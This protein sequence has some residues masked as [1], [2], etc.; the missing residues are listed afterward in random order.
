[1]HRKQITD[2][3]P[4]DTELEKTLR[5]LRKIKK[6]ENS[7]MADE[8]QEHNDEH[9]EAVRRPPITDTMEDFWRPII[10]DE[11]SAIRQ[12]AVEANN[13][14]LKPALITMVQQHQFTGHPTEDP[15][16]HLGRFLRMANTVKL[17][18]VRP[19]VIKL[20]LFPF[21]LRDT[22]ATWYVSS[23]Y[24]SVDSWDELVEA[25][26]CRFFPPSLTSERRREII[27]FQQGED[28]SLYVAWERFK[29]LLKRCPMHGI[30][31]KTQMD[32]VYHALNDISKGIIDASCCG[33]FKR[34]SAEEA[35]DLIEDLAKCNMK[36]PSEFSRGNSRGKGILELNK[37]VA[38]EAKL[39]VIMHRM[40][41]QER[42]TYT[43]HE[44]GAVEKEILKGNADRAVDEQL[45]E[46]EEV[47]YL[48]EQR[49][50][51]FKPNTNLPTH[52]HPALR[53]HENLSY[54]GGASQ[55]PRQVQNPP[56]G[57]QQPPR[58]QQQQQGI[59]H[60]N[61]YQ[62]QRRALSF[63][64]QMLQFMGDNKKL[65]ILHEQKFAELGATAT[66]FQVFQNT[67]NATLKNL[68]TQVGQLAL[69]LQSQKKDA[70]PSDTKKNP[71]DCMAVQLR[72]GKELEKMTEKN[73]NSTEKESPE[74]EEELE[75]KKERVDR[76]DIHDP[77]PA[78][79]FPQRLQ[80]S[81]IEE[82]FA[83]F[84]KT[85]QKLEISMPFTEVVTQMP[86]Y[87]KFLKDILSKK[88]KIVREGIV[89][90]TATCSALMKKE[91]PEKMKDPGSFTIPCMIEGVEI[92]KALC[93]SGASINLMP[94][95]VAKQLSL[96]ELIPTTI[97]LQMADRSM[98][99]PE[100]VLEDV[101]VTVGK[102]VFP[103]DFIILDMEE[104]SQVPLLLG[105]PFLATGAALIDMQKGVLTL[106]VGNEAAAFD[107]IKGMQNIDIDKESC[108][109]VDDVYVL[110]S[111]VHK[112]CNDQI[113]INE[114]EMNFQYIEDDYPDCPYN[115]FH[116]IETVMSMTLNRDE[117]EGN[118]EKGEIQQETSE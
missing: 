61:E 8:R 33:A 117:Q 56:Q 109:V 14:E 12:P 67:T 22:A 40:D 107:L 98:V 87:A 4:A 71:K 85:F 11:Y 64:E 30:G 66:N 51:H 46:T 101:L 114:K 103:V 110:Q 80:K 96:G 63:E 35:R 15:N 79:P 10:Q 21:S 100:G 93:D 50:Y 19:E 42:K 116:S 32:I 48:G 53:N 1:M 37:M 41:K 43:A 97:T 29:R 36:T 74:K 25:Y 47:K 7:T 75:R 49:N 83:R 82:Q 23:P 62:G 26:L 6:A 60:I 106:R 115:S 55:G 102:F 20:H 39:D 99:K 59:E 24:G 91:L 27:V 86:L 52:Y 44:I 70:F 28:E 88:R 112:D 17:N 108:N 31:L 118:N 5:S 45:Y 113:F 65:L 72:S 3:I 58:F 84:L 54:G 13:F 92:Q 34:K 104:D 57:Y 76:N 111:D 78:V 38:M 68:E 95:S 105:R 81:K 9:R 16:E 2:L 18:G 90:L 73:D 77:R 94:L 89:N 69:T